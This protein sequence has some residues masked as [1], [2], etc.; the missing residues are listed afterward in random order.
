M[1]YEVITGI[2]VLAVAI[3]PYFGFG[4]MQ[5][6]NAEAAGVTNDKLH[7]RITLV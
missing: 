4:G 7:P 3:L 1:L 6:Y 2:L 5:L